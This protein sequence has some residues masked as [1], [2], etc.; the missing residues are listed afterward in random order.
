MIS[1]HRNAS[2]PG[3]GEV[4][5]TGKFT[6]LCLSL[7]GR[8]AKN[9]LQIAA[10][11]D[12][13][14][15]I[16]HSPERLYCFVDLGSDA[17]RTELRAF[18]LNKDRILAERRSYR[19]PIRHIK[20]Q[21]AAVVPESMALLTLMPSFQNR[22]HWHQNACSNNSVGAAVYCR[23]RVRRGVSAESRW[24]CY[25]GHYFCACR[26]RRRIE[27]TSLKS[28]GCAACYAVFDSA[29]KFFRIHVLTQ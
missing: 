23:P 14:K 8:A 1:R 25:A 15:Y 26:R 7:E 13:F 28:K 22:L 5:S 2:S 24:G 11:G 12:G 21:D 6:E 4:K 27:I 10:W 20:P 18:V 19:V 16:T 3:R 17:A 9:V 29:K